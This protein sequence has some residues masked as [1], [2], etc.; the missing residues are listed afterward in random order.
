MTCIGFL[1]D[2]TKGTHPSDG[3]ASGCCDLH[4]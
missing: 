4:D 3:V 2:R 1:S